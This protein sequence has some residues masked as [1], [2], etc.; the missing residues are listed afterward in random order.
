MERLER[1]ITIFACAVVGLLILL[2]VFLVGA[3]VVDGRH[4]QDAVDACTNACFPS[5]SEML[6]GGGGA[7]CYCYADELSL[8]RIGTE[9]NP[10]P[11]VE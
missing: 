6:A 7:G 8:Y 4:R 5:E 9:H 2:L 3:A 10:L 11:E 1:V